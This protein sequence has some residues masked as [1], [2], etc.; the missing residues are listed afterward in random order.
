MY[1]NRILLENYRGVRRSEVAFKPTGVTV[2]HG[3]NE[4]GKSSLIEALDLM[5]RFPATTSR[6]EVQVVRPKGRA[7]DP[8]TEIEISAGE[9][10]L[11]YRKLWRKNSGK[12]ELHILEPAAKRD[13]FVNNEAQAK[14]EQLLAECDVDLELW[15]LLRV[16]QDKPLGR[17]SRE[18][19]LGQPTNFVVRPAVAA[20]LGAGAKLDAPGTAEGSMSTAFSR[21]QERLFTA[22]EKAYLCYYTPKT[23]EPTREYSDAAKELTEATAKE[24]EAK[25]ALVVAQDTLAEHER[26]KSELRALEEELAELSSD[27]EA[28]EQRLA[29][30]EQLTEQARTLKS[31][32]ELAELVADAANELAQRRAAFDDDQA[33]Y[34]DAKA[35]FESVERTHQQRLEAARKIE[36]LS[37]QLADA[38][39]SSEKDA[40]CLRDKDLLT[41]LDRAVAAADRAQKRI[42]VADTELARNG[43]DRNA[44]TVISDAFS[45]WDK[46]ESALETNAATVQIERLGDAPVEVNGP[47]AAEGPGA[48]RLVDTVTVEAAGVVRVVV[49]PGSGEQS[50]REK[51]RKTRVAYEQACRDAGVVDLSQA[52]AMALDYDVAVAQRQVALAELTASLSGVKGEGK[53]LA[54]VRQRA[55]NL[56]AAIAA[57]VERRPPTAQALPESIAE[58]SER[59]VKAQAASSQH[60][61]R[62][63][64]AGKDAGAADRELAESRERLRGSERALQ[65]SD[66]LVK[67]AQANIERMPALEAPEILEQAR[68][69]HLQAEARLAELNPSQLAAVQDNKRA[70]EGQLRE[71]AAELTVRAAGL[72]ALIADYGEHGPQEAA[73]RARDRAAQAQHRFSVLQERAEAARL[74]LATLTKHR[75]AQH[76]RYAAPF[77]DLVETYA[78]AVFGNKVNLQVNEDLTISSKTVDGSTVPFNSLS[79][80]TREQLA[81]LG[82]IACAQLIAPGSGGVPLILDDTLGHSDRQRIDQIATILDRIAGTGAQ[83]IILTHA[84]ERF[85]IGSAARV[86]LTAA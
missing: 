13:Q 39:T 60:E 38:L 74:L 41:R 3:P 45:A 1:L 44:L 15:K 21:P 71:N 16:S 33:R 79:T 25:Q 58:A 8:V 17:E 35:K 61:V 73:E 49:A 28:R 70:V 86:D 20:A 40:D 27:I 46:A 30:A 68:V 23:G 52:Q 11:R 59:H 10:R 6:Q 50:R 14:F 78:E 51:E 64:A 85:R 54:A 19:P 53:D 62:L 63:K 12:T 80:G 82:R 81:L 67:R 42:E 83:V 56:R 7:E 31:R 65:Q 72:S 75:S 29:E 9:Y 43:I 47:G 32:L 36:A 57:Y 5:L 55:A 26:I 66:E 37:G 84:P 4:I 34:E 48:I 77:R 24:G 69:H 76:A 18:E 2:V 22:V